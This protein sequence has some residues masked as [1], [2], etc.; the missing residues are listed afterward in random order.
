MSFTPQFSSL[1]PIRVGIVGT[2]YAAKRR[3]ETFLEDERSQ[4]CL[5]TGHTAENV[6]NFC[7]SYQVAACE[8]YEALVTDANIDLVVI[9]TVNRDHGKIAKLALESG[10]HVLIEYPLS[11]DIHEA[12]SLLNLAKKQA[13][14]LHIEHIEILGGMHQAIRQF[15]PQ[16]GTVFYGRYITIDAKNPAP[17][18][19]TYH[20]Q[21]FGFPLSAALPRIHRFTNLFGNVK[22]VT[23]HDRYWDTEGGH[24][25]ARFCDAQLKF[26]NGLIVDIFY[27]KGDIFKESQ[28]TFELSGDQGK[29]SFDGMEG[30]LITKAEK[31]P[32]NLNSRRGLFAQDSIMVL[33]HLCEE[34]PLYI[35]PESSLYASRVADA[36]YQS[37]VLEKTVEVS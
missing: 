25:H 33:D 23:C 31:T 10:K 17:R 15:L 16:L 37:S 35:Q 30:Q 19:W 34:K 24:Y 2:G 8:T 21:L 28:R 1:S 18:R 36:A 20:H 14:L 11:L 22:T 32:I 4:L 12:S 6:K 26:Q 27:G 7:Q 9:C 3:A 13:K 5:V 29:I